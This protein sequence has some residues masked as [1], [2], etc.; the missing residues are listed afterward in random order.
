MCVSMIVGILLHLPLPKVD[1]LHLCKPIMF[2]GVT[3]LC[4]FP[5]FFFVRKRERESQ[6][7]CDEL[8]KQ[9]QQNNR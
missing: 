9:P 2:R 5:L 3:T 6:I 7:T 1:K 8:I 4:F